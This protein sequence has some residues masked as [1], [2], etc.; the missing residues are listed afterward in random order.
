[1]ELADLAR[2]RGISENVRIPGHVHDMPAAL[3]AADIAVF[4]ST[5]P[6]AFGRGAVEAQAMGV[7]VVVAA[8][9]GLRETVEDGVTGLFTPP[10]DPQALA[11]AILRLIEAGPDE[12][13]SMGA[14]GRDRALARYSVEALKQ[15][16]LSVY[17]RLLD[18]G[19]REAGR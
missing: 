14:R 12:R 6:E 2:G 16:T 1:M 9:G 10:S 4:P 11:Q 3:A 5:D 19:R 18:R 15:A 13:R 7:P 17:R 8:H